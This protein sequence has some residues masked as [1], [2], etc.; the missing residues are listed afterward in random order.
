LKK[1]PI[2]GS[3]KLAQSIDSIDRNDRMLA[4]FA[5]IE[6][7]NWPQMTAVHHFLTHF[8]KLAYAKEVLLLI[9]HEIVRT[10]L[11]FKSHEPLKTRHFKVRITNHTIAV[12]YM[13]LFPVEN[14]SF[15]I[16]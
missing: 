16:G 6:T 11:R 12:D 7:S 8:R 13:H 5:R 3:V 1:V 9:E 4:T 2:V 15:L 10:N 14:L